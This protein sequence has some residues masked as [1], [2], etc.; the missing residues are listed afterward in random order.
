ML[1]GVPILNEVPFNSM[2]R[3][4]KPEDIAKALSL[5]GSDVVAN[6]ET[7]RGV[8]GFLDKFLFEKARHF[9]DTLDLQDFW[10]C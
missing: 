8:K 10:R 1:L 2:E 7:R 9:W 4:H 6:W 5:Q 3:D